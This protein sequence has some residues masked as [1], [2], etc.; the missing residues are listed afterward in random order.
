[1]VEDVMMELNQDINKT[2][3]QSI[4]HEFQIYMDEENRYV[5]IYKN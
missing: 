3:L 2:S 1:M 4:K 5:L